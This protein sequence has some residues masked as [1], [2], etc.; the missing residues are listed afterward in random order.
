MIKLTGQPL[1]L[2][3]RDVLELEGNYL[4]VPSNQGTEI[5]RALVAISDL[6]EK[7]DK[8]VLVSTKTWCYP[9]AIKQGFM[10][11]CRHYKKNF[12][13]VASSISKFPVPGTAYFIL[14]DTDLAEMIGV[15]NVLG[16]RMGQDLGILS[17]DDSPLKKFVGLTVITTELAST[18]LTASKFP[19]HPQL[20][21]SMGMAI[22]IR[23]AS[24]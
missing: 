7:Y 6:L 12:A 13:I 9:P 15:C 5:C 14:N 11:Y 8:L 17:L 23:R 19:Q 20:Q 21:K 24:L 1:S 4:A 3:Q 16:Y 22:V 10:Q 18:T 2:T